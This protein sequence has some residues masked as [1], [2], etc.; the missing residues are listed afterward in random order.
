MYAADGVCMYVNAYDFLA[1]TI[2][3]RRSRSRLLTC[4]HLVRGKPERWRRFT[5]QLVLG[6]I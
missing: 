1:V 6:N 4:F 3:M 5:F 2:F